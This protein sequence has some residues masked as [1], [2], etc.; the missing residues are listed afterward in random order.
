[1]LKVSFIN[2]ILTTLSVT[3]TTH[4]VFALPLNEVVKNLDS[5]TPFCYMR[6]ADGRIL[7]LRNI[8]GF[9]SPAACS[10]R[11]IKPEIAVLLKDFCK[12]NQRCLITSTC[13]VV[14]PTLEPSTIGEPR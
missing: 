1:M 9:A 5:N 4:S 11:N 14:P 2:S 13:N 8:C 12:Q 7:D 10:E 6:T 3:L